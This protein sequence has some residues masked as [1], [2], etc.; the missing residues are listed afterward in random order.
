MGIFVKKM[1]ALG[2]FPRQVTLDSV[3]WLHNHYV[4]L[5]IRSAVSFREN[6]STILD[7]IILEYS[8]LSLIKKF[9]FIF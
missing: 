2:K 3:V 1:S 7:D 5:T 9:K 6:S 4:L 8:K